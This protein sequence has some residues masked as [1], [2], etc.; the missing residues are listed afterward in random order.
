PG[1]EGRARAGGGRA[2]RGGR[3]RSD[4]PRG[5]GERAVRARRFFGDMRAALLLILCACGSPAASVKLGTAWPEK[6]AGYADAYERWTRRAAH[7]VDLVQG[8]DASATPAGPQWRAPHAAARAR[9]T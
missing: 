5:P 2:R 3:A 8:I 1:A 6:P 4:R 9:P 7:S